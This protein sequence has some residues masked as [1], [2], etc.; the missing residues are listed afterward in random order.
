MTPTTYLS[1]LCARYVKDGL[2]VFLHAVAQNRFHRAPGAYLIGEWQRE[3]RGF[4]RASKELIAIVPK[5]V[6]IAI[7]Q[8]KGWFVGEDERL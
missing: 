5:D 6:V 2:R 3:K 7:S 4:R 1:P 8:H